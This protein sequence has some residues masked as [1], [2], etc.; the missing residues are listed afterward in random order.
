MTI[1][2]S[3]GI[4]SNQEL[5]LLAYSPSGLRLLTVYCFLKCGVR[6]RFVV[7]VVIYWVDH[8]NAHT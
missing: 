8:P 4:V 3:H 5:L 2:A 6:V 1:L 7:R